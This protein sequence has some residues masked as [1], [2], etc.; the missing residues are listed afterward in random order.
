MGF[1]NNL[2]LRSDAIFTSKMHQTLSKPGIDF[3]TLRVGQALES[4]L[5]A[6]N[7]SERKTLLNL[8]KALAK[9]GDISHGDANSLVHLMNEFGNKGVS[10]FNQSWPFPDL[11]LANAPGNV[12][13]NGLMGA[14]INNYGID[15]GWKA[16]ISDLL[17]QAQ[18]NIFTDFLQNAFNNA[19]FMNLNFMERTE[20]TAMVS[21]AVSDGQVNW[22]EA[23]M[24]MDK[25]QQ[26]QTQGFPPILIPDRNCWE[27]CPCPTQPPADD[28]E[29]QQTG[30]GKASIDL[31]NYTLDLNE[32]SSEMILTNKETGESSRIWGDPH[33]DMDNDGKTD[34]DFWG[35]ISL[36]LADGTKITIDTTPWKGNEDM[37]LASKL[38]ITNGD[39]AIVVDGLDQ[40]KIGDMSIK[41][42]DQ[43]RLLDALN[44]DGLDVYENTM[45]EGFLV[46]DGLWLRP[47]TQDD[48]N[49]T[50]NQNTDFSLLDS[51]QAMNAMFSSSFLAG[52]FHSLLNE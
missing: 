21:V 27:P 1:F 39:R 36:N 51:L 40:N 7:L 41:Q 8:T 30:Q 48:M 24:I 4:N 33:F 6:L 44:G 31:G 29:I 17:G 34:V 23:K 14:I 52:L 19:N 15:F 28:W 42:S 13:F 11:N 26:A 5:D 38:T 2:H 20:L 18:P 47:V 46:K 25:L 37:T 22:P 35:T 45:G 50:K 10:A 49:T 9:D 43:G 32:R 12:L 16:G 3:N